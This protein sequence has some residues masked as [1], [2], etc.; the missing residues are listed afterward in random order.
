MNVYD[1]YVYLTICEV[2]LPMVNKKLYSTYGGFCRCLA[3]SIEHQLLSTTEKNMIYKIFSTLK[4]IYGMSDKEIGKYINEYF[5]KGLHV[6]FEKSV[7]LTKEYFPFTG[8]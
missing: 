1:N 7:R 5:T 3:W 4:T 6:H 8:D 2:S